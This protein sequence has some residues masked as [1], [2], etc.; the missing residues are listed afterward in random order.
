M[1]KIYASI[2]I[3]LGDLFTMYARSLFLRK[4]V[5]RRGSMRIL[6]DS[7][8]KRNW[9]EVLANYNKTGINIGHQQDHWM[10]L[11]EA[12]RAQTHAE[13]PFRM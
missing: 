4:N 3:T 8:R 11:K 5:C 2:H 7:E 6:T 9:K 13:V 10:E 12:L 1:T